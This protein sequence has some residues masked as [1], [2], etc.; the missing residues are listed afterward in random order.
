MN[1]TK[2]HIEAFN[3]ARHILSPVEFKVYERLFRVGPMTR[4]EINLCDGEYR[5]L[6]RRL[7]LLERRGAVAVI[8]ERI[9]SK[10]G[11]KCAV[12][13]VTSEKPGPAERS[14]N[15]P[16]RP[17]AAVLRGALEELKPFLKE[18][19]AAVPHCLELARWLSEVAPKPS[20]E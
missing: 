14:R 9:C 7:S 2:A 1:R 3:A 20:D 11:R 15:V 17:S 4:N 19:G 16:E 8:G 12:Y 13:D 10:T 18:K 6:D 5:P